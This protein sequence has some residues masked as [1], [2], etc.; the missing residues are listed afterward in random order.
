MHVTSIYNWY[1]CLVFYIYFELR[2]IDTDK[3]TKIIKKTKEEIIGLVKEIIL[4]D[5]IANQD[6]KNKEK[7]IKSSEERMKF[8][9]ELEKKNQ[10]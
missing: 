6:I 9:M 8:V 4:T 2:N 5:E 7:S 3:I 1:I 10:K